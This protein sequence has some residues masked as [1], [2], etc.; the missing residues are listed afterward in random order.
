[1]ET[2]G[3]GIDP[4]LV[5]SVTRPDGSRQAA[6]NRRPLYRLNGEAP[7]STTGH[8]SGGEWSLMTSSGVALPV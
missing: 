2:V 6:Y 5:G 1:V 7:G 3:P 4:T 8:G